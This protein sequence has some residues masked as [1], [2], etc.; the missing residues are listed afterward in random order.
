[1]VHIQFNS[2]PKLAILT[3]EC[4][5]VRVGNRHSALTL[6]VFLRLLDPKV[7]NTNL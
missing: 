4:I 1:M 5:C 3:I 7:S 2:D 6:I